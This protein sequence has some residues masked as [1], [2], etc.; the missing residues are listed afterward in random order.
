[1][2]PVA[3]A[4]IPLAVQSANEFLQCPLTYTEHLQ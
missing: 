4:L 2:L 3:I 1:M